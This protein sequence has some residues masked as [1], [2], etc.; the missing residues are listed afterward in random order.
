MSYGLLLLRVIV[1]SVFFAHGAQKLFGWWGGGGLQGTA[2]WLGSSGFRPPLL[3]ALMVALSESAGALFVLGLATPFA[4]LVMASVMVVAVGHVHWKNGFFSGKGGYEFNLTL[5]GA[6]VAVA[7]TGPGRFSLDHAFG[8]DDN[9]S[10]LWWGVGVLALS[11][12]GGL[13]VL[14]TKGTPPPPPPEPDAA[15]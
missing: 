4:A 5:W 13:L 1:G 6:A 10:G 2:K 15:A 9:I 14:A 7:A 11:L 8:W 12:A 3:M